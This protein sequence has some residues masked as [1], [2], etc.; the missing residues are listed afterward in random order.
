MKRWV[1]ATLWVFVVMATAGSG[2]LVRLTDGDFGTWL[3][4]TAVLAVSAIA[5]HYV[6]PTPGRLVVERQVEL[7]LSDLIFFVYPQPARPAEPQVPRDY[8]LQLHMAVA[9]IGRRKAVLSQLS[10]NYFLTETGRRVRLPEA[11]QGPLRAHKWSQFRQSPDLV[12]TGL[13]MAAQLAYPPFTLE[14]DDVETLRFRLRRGVDWSD[15]W[16]ISKLKQYASELSETI[17][18]VEGDLVYRSGKAI[19]K[20]RW[21]S[22]LSV[23]NQALYRQCLE[24]L[25]QG[26]TVRPLIP[27]QGIDIE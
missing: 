26:F 23:V 16:T 13:R 5:L 4:S 21:A 14:P 10:L 9:N 22:N 15:R 11:V 6:V 8:L 27:A 7:D 19:V 20:Q 12:I 25:T 2:A 18:G 3:V 1:E 24:D 17:V